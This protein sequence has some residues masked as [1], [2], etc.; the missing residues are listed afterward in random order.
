MA[1]LKILGDQKL[2]ERVCYM[3]KPK[4]AKFQPPTRDRFWAILK[5]PAG[6]GKFAPL[7]HPK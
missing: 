7:P 3:L 2:F 5:K 4:V 6:G 1:I